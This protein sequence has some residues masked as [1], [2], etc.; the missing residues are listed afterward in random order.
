M[1]VSA[2]GILGGVFNPIHHGHLAIARIACDVLKLS[3]VYFVPTAHPP[4]KQH[5]ITSSY[6]RG[7]MVA[8]SLRGVSWARIYDEELKRKSV[9][10]TIDTIHDLRKRHPRAELFFIIG[11]DNLA[12]IRTWVRYREIIELV[13]LVVFERP[14]YPVKIPAALGSARLKIIPSPVWG[15]SSTQLRT[16][17][18]DKIS[19]EY[20]IPEAVRT[21]IRNHRL[22]R[23]V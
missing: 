3:F 18:A 16:M 10:Y 23:T 13:T 19:C 7:I 17:L 22:Y 14:G 1:K 5:K 20:L 21:Y 6:H 12:Q 4:H 8:T 11:S 15:L 9:S 2:I